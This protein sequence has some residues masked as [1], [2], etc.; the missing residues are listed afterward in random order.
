[1]TETTFAE[2]TG[3]GVRGSQATQVTNCMRRVF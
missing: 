3:D 1:M 2:A